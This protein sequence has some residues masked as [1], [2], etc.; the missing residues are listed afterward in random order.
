[1]GEPLSRAAPGTTV[2]FE[3]NRQRFSGEP[4]REVVEILMTESESSRRFASRG[5]MLNGA[6]P[7]ASLV[8]RESV[9]PSAHQYC[10]FRFVP[11]RAVVQQE[12]AQQNL[13]QG[14]HSFDKAALKRTDTKEKVVLPDTEGE[15][16]PLGL[17]FDFPFFFIFGRKYQ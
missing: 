17:R 1:M 7:V 15:N 13:L 6:A 16:E 8:R 11:R 2:E 3:P 4:L 10:Y 12:K 9:V 5:V 14:V